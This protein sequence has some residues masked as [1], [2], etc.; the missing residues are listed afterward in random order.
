MKYV[1]LIIIKIYWFIIPERRRKNCLFC[2]SC[3]LFVFKEAKL[4]GFVSGVMAFRN[5][6]NSCRPGY[7]VIRIE[8]ENVILLKLANGEVLHEKSISKTIVNQYK[9]R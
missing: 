1:L 2:E 3:S 8:E 5:R 9:Q 6:Y 7:D 4:K